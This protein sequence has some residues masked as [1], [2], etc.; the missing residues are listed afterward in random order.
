MRSQALTSSGYCAPNHSH[1]AVGG[2]SILKA[3]QRMAEILRIVPGSSLVVAPSDLDLADP[4]LADGLEDAFGGGGYTALQRS[5]LLQMAW[6]HIA[7]ALDGRESAFEQ[8]ASGGLPAWRG[9]L[10]RSF[11][12]YNELANGVLR[13]LDMDMPEIDLSSLRETAW[14]PRRPVTPPTAA[15]EGSG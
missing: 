14:A 1:L 12:R 15:A 8:H 3:R 2:I 4:D 13:A 11:E 6:D 10:R 5:A 9:R 7:S